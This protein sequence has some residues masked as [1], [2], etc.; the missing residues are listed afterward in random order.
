MVVLQSL[1][2]ARDKWGREQADAIWDASTVKV[3]LGGSSN[4]DDL[5][6]LSRMI[7]DRTVRERSQSWQA[8]GGRSVSESERERAILDPAM[9]RTLPFG[10]GLL[11]LRSA[12]PIMLTLRPWTN[13]HDAAAVKAGQVAVEQTIRDAAAAEWGSDA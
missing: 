13:R 1:A 7:G 2:Q 5:G 11:L 12:K 10:Y 9:I 3:I 4:A 6:D 8:G